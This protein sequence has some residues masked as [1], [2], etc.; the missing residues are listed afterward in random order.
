MKMEIYFY[1]KLKKIYDRPKH[2]YTLNREF[3]KLFLRKPFNRKVKPASLLAVALTKC[4][5]HLS[6]Y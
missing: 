3:D 2:V 1:L 4:S 6:P 5:V